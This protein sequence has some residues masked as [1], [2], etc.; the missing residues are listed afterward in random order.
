MNQED[1]IFCKIIK[2]EIPSNKIYEN[3]LVYAF[4]DI[5]PAAPQHFL[6]IP[7]VHKASLNE[8]DDNDREL[9]GEILLTAKKIASEKGF[10]Q[11]GYRTIINTGKD[12]G[13]TV[14][15]LHLHVLAGRALTWP[16]G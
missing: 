3:D 16:P 5:N 8:F 2:G 10:D 9:L 7:K 13:Q 12:G 6:V 14:H 11:D 4:T 15:H 1:C